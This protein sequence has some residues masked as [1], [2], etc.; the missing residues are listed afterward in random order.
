[1]DKV[2]RNMTP[3]T[4]VI[5]NKRQLIGKIAIQ[6]TVAGPEAEGDSLSLGVHVIGTLDLLS[7]RNNCYI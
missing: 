7:P 3:R 6:I 2:F 5:G 4:N 1:M